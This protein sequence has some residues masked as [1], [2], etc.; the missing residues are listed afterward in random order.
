[1]TMDD[2]DKRMIVLLSQDARISVS[3]LARD[4][5]L[6]RST[7]QAR[8]ERLERHKIIA[9]YTLKLGDAVRLGRIRAT[10]LL[11]IEPRSTAAVVA[12][13]K[14]LSEVE[15]AHTCSGRFDMVLELA[16]QT[17]AAMDEALDEIG[18]IKGVR[19]SESLIQLTTKF[20]R[21]L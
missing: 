2:I 14:S 18:G 16:S 10:V 8:L 13:L 1:M 6:A 15:V 4:L 7:V 3:D 12:R 19:S 11:Q 9:G 20:D 5:G 17:T 21:S